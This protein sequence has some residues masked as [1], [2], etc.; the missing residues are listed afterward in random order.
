MT[1]INYRLTLRERLKNR[2][3]WL[4]DYLIY[5]KHNEYLSHKNELLGILASIL[6][7]PSTYRPFKIERDI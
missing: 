4:R 6:N 3:E 2:E 1:T 7:R 5:R